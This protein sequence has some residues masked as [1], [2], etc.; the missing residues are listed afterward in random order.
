MLFSS[1][2]LWPI[3]RT[4]IER[5]ISDFEHLQEG[6]WRFDLGILKWPLHSAAKNPAEGIGRNHRLLAGSLR[7]LS[8]CTL[9][10]KPTRALHLAE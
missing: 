3:M 7:L 9:R 8:H 6:Y 5:N 2:L 4:A 1:A 10:M